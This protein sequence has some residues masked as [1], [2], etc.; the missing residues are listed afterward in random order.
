M[1][2]TV[3]RQRKCDVT[4]TASTSRAA[5]KKSSVKVHAS[6]TFLRVMREMKVD[7]SPNTID[8][9]SHVR[10]VVG[11]CFSTSSSSSSSSEKSE[12]SAVKDQWSETPSVFHQQSDDIPAAAASTVAA[13]QAWTRLRLHINASSAKRRHEI[14]IVERWQAMCYFVVRA[15]HV[16]H[17][18]QEL[19]R[20]YIDCPDT[21][22]IGL[23]R[24][25]E[26]EI[27]PNLGN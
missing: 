16:N 11:G 3:A 25:Q 5:C 24:K 14:G 7:G 13:R 6:D 23:K 26:D 4:T 20:R 1:E 17:S 18:R 12:M 2:P 9:L 10:N 22:M 19:Y 15:S 21:W 8:S 27:V